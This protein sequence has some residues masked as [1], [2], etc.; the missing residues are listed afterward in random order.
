MLAN[1]VNNEAVEVQE[2]F[3]EMD[4]MDKLEN[5]AVA[6]VQRNQSTLMLLFTNERLLT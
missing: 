1:I 2:E 5:P 3:V 4:L 6:A